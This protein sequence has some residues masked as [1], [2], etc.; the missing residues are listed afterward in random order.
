M[1]GYTEVMGGVHGEWAGCSDHP[2][3]VPCFSLFARRPQ[4]PAFG[5]GIRRPAI[6]GRSVGR[7]RICVTQSDS[8]T[9]VQYSVSSDL[10][11]LHR[12]TARSPG[13]CCTPPNANIQFSFFLYYHHYHPHR[14]TCRSQAH[15]NPSQCSHQVL[16]TTSQGLTR[17]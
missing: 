9:T 16:S 5:P 15:S 8:P 12:P 3:P 10:V 11:I 13:S 6:R 1:E 14:P 17:P 7:G 2:R 4:R